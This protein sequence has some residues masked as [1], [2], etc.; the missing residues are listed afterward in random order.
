MA[1]LY[2]PNLTT[3]FKLSRSKVE[4][5]LKCPYCFYLDRRLGIGQPSGPPFTLNNAVDALLKNECD[6]YRAQKKPHPIAVANNLSAIPYQPDPADLMAKW[7]N[8][9]QCISFLHPATN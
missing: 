3:P 7:R 5:F 1:A 6:G 2:T 9:R 8:N 4:N